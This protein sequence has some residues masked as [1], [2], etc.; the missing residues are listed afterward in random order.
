MNVHVHACILIHVYICKK[1]ITKQLK[2]TKQRKKFI[3]LC[4]CVLAFMC[5]FLLARRNAWVY[6]CAC[7]SPPFADCSCHPRKNVPAQQ[8]AI[9]LGIKKQQ[10]NPRVRNV[11]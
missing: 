8:L 10:L 6:V 4:E 11:H 7:V 2:I 1:S 3:H 9:K 5:V